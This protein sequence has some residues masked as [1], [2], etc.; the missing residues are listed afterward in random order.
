MSRNL[1]TLFEFLTLFRNLSFFRIQELETALKEEYANEN[2][3]HSDDDV[4]NITGIARPNI[5]QSCLGVQ[6]ADSK[7]DTFDDIFDLPEQ[8]VLREDCLHFVCTYSVIIYSSSLSNIYLLF[9][10]VQPN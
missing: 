4:D 10:Y 2:L 1:Q 8:K 3:R 6:E 9:L 7:M 5:W